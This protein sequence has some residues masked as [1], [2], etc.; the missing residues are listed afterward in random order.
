MSLSSLFTFLT[1]TDANEK[2]QAKEEKKKREEDASHYH[3]VKRTYS[4]RLIYPMPNVT[5]SV[6]GG[7]AVSGG[8]GS[9]SVSGSTY[10]TYQLMIFYETEG[11]QCT[12]QI[13]DTQDIKE[14]LKFT[15][16]ESHVVVQYQCADSDNHIMNI[17][18]DAVYVNRHWQQV[19]R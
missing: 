9:V 7:G 15:D 19:G 14:L 18:Y 11:G 3:M 16:D 2:K 5:G 4:I 17:F 6:S 13:F 8:S 1:K 10:T 12:W